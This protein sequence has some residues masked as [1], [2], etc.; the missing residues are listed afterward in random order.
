MVKFPDF[1][2]RPR[3]FTKYWARFSLDLGETW[4]LD[5]KLAGHDCLSETHEV[6]IPEAVQI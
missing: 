3:H 1:V 4:N 2:M 6:W 5:V